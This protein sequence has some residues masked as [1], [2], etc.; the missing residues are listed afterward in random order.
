MQIEMFAAHAARELGQVRVLRMGDTAAGDT[1]RSLK[2]AKAY[3]NAMAQEAFIFAVLAEGHWNFA[4]AVNGAIQFIDYQTDH[5]QLGGRPTVGAEFLQEALGKGNVDES[6]NISTP[7]LH[8]TRKITFRTVRPRDLSPS[9]G[10]I[11]TAARGRL[12]V[13]QHRRRRGAIEV[14]VNSRYRVNTA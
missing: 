14:S 5:E 11:E 7:C 13:R 1:R 2:E 3:M 10:L 6:K 9:A 12:R 8:S 4:H